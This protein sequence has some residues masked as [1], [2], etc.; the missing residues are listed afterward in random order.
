MEDSGELEIRIDRQYANNYPV[1]VRFTQAQSDVEND[2]APTNAAP[3]QL[4]LGRLRDLEPDPY[5]YGQALTQM[6]FG[7]WVGDALTT[8]RRNS[9]TL[10]TA[11]RVRLFI[12]PSAWDLHSLR[13][14]T[15][16][17]PASGDPLL[18][19]ERLLFSRFLSSDDWRRVQRRSQSDLRALVVIAN[20]TGLEKYAP[21]GRPLSQIDVERELGL[22]R[23][24]LNGMG[25]QVLTHGDGPPASIVKVA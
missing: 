3:L 7:G 11:L 6:L 19:S 16:R 21:A 18:T 15:L 12:T 14:E 17:D 25:P 13:W 5:A 9:M 8:A 24:G 10:D 22:A 4:D 23:V 1:E 2:L 20:P